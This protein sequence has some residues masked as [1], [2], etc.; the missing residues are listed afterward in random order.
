MLKTIIGFCRLGLRFLPFLLSCIVLEKA[1]FSKEKR[2]RQFPLIPIAI[3]YCIIM[4]FKVD[5]LTSRV[6]ALIDLLKK[7]IPFLNRFDW[8]YWTLLISNLVV[9]ILYIALKG[10]LMPLLALAWKIAERYLPKRNILFYRWDEEEKAYFLNEKWGQFKKL[11][12]IFYYAIAAYGTTLLVMSYYYRRSMEVFSYSFYPIY[13]IIVFCEIASYLNGLTYAEHLEKEPEEEKQEHKNDY[14]GLRDRYVETYKNRILSEEVS[15]RPDTS[16]ETPQE[17]IAQLKASSSNV[18]QAYGDYLQRE[19]DLGNALSVEY[20]LSSRDMLR[21]KSVLFANPFYRDLSSSIF[22]PFNISLLRHSNGLI[23][24]GKDGIEDEIRDWVL[25]GLEEISHVPNFWRIGVI[26]E[27]SG[28]DF[29]IGILSLKDMNN[30]K[31]LSRYNSFFSGVGFV[32]MLE[33]SRIVTMNQLALSILSYMIG[34]DGRD[35]VY[36]GCD[37]NTDGSVDALSHILRTSITQVG[38]TVASSKLSTVLYWNI[39]GEHLQYRLYRNIVRYLGGGISIASIA[40][41]HGIDK[42]AWFADRAMPV[43]DIRWIAGQYFAP[44]MEYVGRT[45]SQ[46]SLQRSIDF[47]NNLWG[48]AALPDGCFIVEDEYCNLYEMGRQFSTRAKEQTFLH[49]LSPSYMLRDYMCSNPA[50]FKADPKA[51]P[52]I[53]ADFA[54]T[55]RNSAMQLIMLLIRN[56]ISDAQIAE[57]LA[58]AQIR[59]EITR[60]FLDELIGEFYDVAGYGTLVRELEPVDEYDRTT[61]SI[62]QR[63]YFTITNERFISVYAS[64]LR[65]AYYLAEDDEA[66]EH[67]LGGRLKG[68]VYQTFLPGQFVTLSGKYYEVLGIQSR[69]DEYPDMVV[70]RRAADHITDRRYY[71]QFRAYKLANCSWEAK[72]IYKRERT[73]SGIAVASGYVDMTVRT[74]GYLEMNSYQDLAHASKTEVAGIPDRV[75]LKKYALRIILPDASDLVRTQICMMMNEIFR[76]VFPE[77]YEYVMAVTDISWCE[78]LGDTGAAKIEGEYAKEAIYILED[79][80]IDLGLTIAVERYLEKI[81]QIICDYSDWSLEKIREAEK[82]AQEEED[83]A[84]EGEGAEGE[85][86]GGEDTEEEEKK[87]KGFFRR[88]IEKIKAFFG[89]IFRRRKKGEEEPEEEPE[90]DGEGEGTAD[91]GGVP[92]EGPEGTAEGE[93]TADDGVI[94]DSAAGDD[95]IETSVGE[96]ASED[97]TGEPSADESSSGTETPQEDGGS[98]TEVTDEEENEPPLPPMIMDET[99]L[100]DVS[101]SADDGSDDLNLASVSEDETGST[102]D[103]EDETGTTTTTE[104]GTG[105]PDDEPSEK[106]VEEEPAFTHYLY[107]GAKEFPEYINVEEVASYLKGLGFGDNPF[108]KVRKGLDIIGEIEE[109]YH[110]EDKT[111][112][113]CDF[114]GKDVTGM[115]HDVLKDGRCRCMECAS[116]AVKTIE[117][118]SEIFQDVRGA[119]ERQFG[120]DLQI[121]IK[122]KMVSA[123]TLARV[124]RF[125]FRP[126]NKYDPRVTG[127]AVSSR[128]GY[129][130]Y[131]ENGAPEINTRETISHELTHIWQYKNW[132]GKKINKLYGSG[133][134]RLEVYEGMAVWVS[135]RFM[136]LTGNTAFAKRLE[137]ASE[138]RDDEYGKGYL[139][140]EEAYGPACLPKNASRTPF[141]EP[142]KPL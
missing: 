62:V 133:R 30:I 105:Q 26:S 125:R 13:G 33:P 119:M 21:G 72:D 59:E 109:T 135:I 130:L 90:G 1:N 126:T 124:S 56:S 27:T 118:F 81:L 45:S 54:R 113:F 63:K 55:R 85:N 74:E 102:Y 39:D 38:A 84:G 9:A 15:R 48:T 83:E 111:R 78:A 7:W 108:V 52:Q 88:I 10:F 37:R 46:D 70:V 65:T 67:F 97:E 18:E 6:F 57:L 29:D 61:A 127:L 79:S 41:K 69:G 136:L 142:E 25:E 49:V 44:I 140:Y 34:R 28:M 134:A 137:I 99:G 131:V 117:E 75:Y 58:S 60:D 23:L 89:K 96:D 76:S 42:V 110:P 17:I 64:E 104:G 101:D 20:I 141:K 91:D 86:E 122:V 51:I 98:W 112:T 94:D 32:L 120:I 106:P 115:E 19:L 100:P 77:C 8:E 53:V 11:Y 73:L 93:G 139:R 87:K 36:C 5:L 92:G 50:V 3:I 103:G 12:I 24:I 43:E 82:A 121:P 47:N 107:Y 14:T 35:V 116:T 123:T 128:G 4:V 31:I 2:Y 129:T 80:Q 40:L 95:S 22:F 71:R 114:C 66:M 68:Q 16:G 138:R 132:D